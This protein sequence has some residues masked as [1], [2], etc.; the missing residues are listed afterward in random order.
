M[1]VNYW[2]PPGHELQDVYAWVRDDVGCP[3][4]YHD[5]LELMLVCSGEVEIS[6]DFRPHTLRSG[7]IMFLFPNRI[8]NKN[9]SVARN[10]VL[11][12]SVDL[13]P[14]FKEIFENRIPV[15][16][17]LEGVGGEPLIN[18]LFTQ[19][20]SEFQQAKTYSTAVINGYLNALVGTL[21]RACDLRECVYTNTSLEMKIITLCSN[22]FRNNLTHASIAAELGVSKYY[23]SHMFTQRLGMTLSDFITT[24]RLNEASRLLSSGEKVSHAAM[25]S[26]FSSVRVFNYTFKRKFDLTPTEYR[27]KY[28]LIGRNAKEK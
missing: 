17:V 24:L 25:A 4:H 2:I 27:E 11:R 3:Y 16:P 7:D 5:Q 1:D 12:F 14:S 8:H 15:S 18:K 26:G 21:L 28:C 20:A 22:S 9:E 19:I 23:L 6:V 13:C 10:I